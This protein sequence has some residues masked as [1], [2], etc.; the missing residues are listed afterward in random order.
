MELEKYCPDCGDSLPVSSFTRD[1]RRRDGLAFYCRDHARQRLRASKARRQGPPKS[2]HV[3]DRLVPEGT[4]WCPDCDT[5]KPLAD[6]PA[7]RSRGSGRHTYCKPCHNARGRATLERLGGSRTYH[8]KRRYGLTAE[9]AD[10]MLEVQGGLC[11]I[12]KAAPA[13]HVDHD[14]ATGRVRALLC[15]NCN[16]GLGQ[17]KDNPAALHAAAYYVQFHTSRQEIAAELD[18]VG[19]G[20]QA[21]G[22]PGEPPVGSQRRPG[23]R[24]STA[25]ASG[26]PSRSRRQQ[27]A[28]EADT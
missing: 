5:I 1:K 24:G 11:A 28:G 9:E 17:F 14:H 3:L 10:T 13:A 22:R 2:R 16:G 27:P 15:F 7:S 25:R 18:A 6:F 19:N 4:Q 26:R 20:P 8:L 21:A 23:T 12:C